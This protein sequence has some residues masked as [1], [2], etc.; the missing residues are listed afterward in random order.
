MA[1]GEGTRLNLGE[2]P[3]LLI[4]GRPMI[5]YV[6]AAFSA[7]GCEPFVAVTQKTLM[8]RNWCRVQGIETYL[9]EGG[10]YVT[11]MV[12]AVLAL[13]ETQPLFVSVSDI[14][15]VH[16]GVIRSILAAYKQSGKDACST[17]VPTRL[18]RACRGGVSYRRTISCEDVCP[19]GVNILTGEM[20]EQTQD[21]LELIVDDP[22]L[23]LN[24]NTRRDRDAAE[25][26][27]VKKESRAEE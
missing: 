21:E 16:P 15:C 25:A 7:A 18:V 23:A 8:T 26:F 10:D 24:V 11:D 2:K 13:E 19:T 4:N 22:C 6:T 1:G 12:E 9:A 20:I 5:Q 27:L 14:P 3:L 17:W